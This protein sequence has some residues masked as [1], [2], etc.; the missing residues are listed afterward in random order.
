MATAE[1]STRGTA[2]A[3]L[4]AAPLLAELTAGWREGRRPLA[5]EVLDRHPALADH[6][7]VAVRL[8][9][10]EVWLREQAGLPVEAAAILERFPRW[11]QELEV[12]LQC[13]VLLGTEGAAPGYPEAGE[14]LH[15]FAL[16]AELG[17]GARGR[18]YLARDPELA[19]RPVVLKV[20][21]LRGGEHRNL[22][23]L[24]HAH[25]VPLLSAADLPDRGLRILC[26]PYHGGAPLDRLLDD[27]ARVPPAERTGRDLIGALDRASAGAPVASPAEGPAR[28]LLAGESYVR[29]VCWV[30]SCLAD[31]LEHAHR[32][33]L[34]HLDVKPSNVL[35]AAEGTPMLLD[36]HL[37][38]G[39]LRAGDRVLN[40]LGGTPGYM[41]PEQQAAMAEVKQG[42]PIS[43]PVDAR[44]DVHALGVLIYQMLAGTSRA[45]E[46]RRLRAANRRVGPGLADVVARCLAEDPARR[47]A[48]AGEFADDLRRFLDDR[49]LRGVPNRSLRERW[50]RW[51]RRHPQ[52]LSRAGASAVAMLGVASAALA[53]GHT[54]SR[55][56]NDAQA[57]LEQG[58][59]YLAEGSERQAVRVLGDAL[60]RLDSAGFLRV[61]VPSAERLHA[62]LAAERERAERLVR[63]EELHELADRLRWVLPADRGRP[64]EVRG[65]ESRLA[66]VWASRQSILGR[67][68]AGSTPPTRERVLADLRDLGLLLADLRAG[69]A[70]DGALR[71]AM[72]ILA[73]VEAACGPSAALDLERAG[74]AGRLGLV[75]EAQAALA[76]AA[77]ARPRTAWE[78]AALG[79]AQ[80]RAGDPRAAAAA[81]DRAV[82]LEPH[83]LWPHFYRGQCALRRGRYAEALSDFSACIALRPEA[84]ACYHNRGLAF[85]GLGE[86]ARA[87][88]DFAQARRLAPRPGRPVTS[89]RATSTLAGS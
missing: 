75:A 14:T 63:L 13:H 44:A 59:A 58:Q 57:A 54:A 78:Y 7:E 69:S 21:S 67:L 4:L 49:P 20:T 39:P 81:L 29:A 66:Q 53:V 84:A 8:V 76:R 70:R 56:L 73:E 40:G 50:G 45:V 30:V 64:A 15:G 82:E 25:I 47:Y 74:V 43:R 68:A 86:R 12:L 2:E 9:Y 89:S 72:A 48:D 17:R 10:E 85:A 23:R 34:V 41:A 79:R 88:R 55:R 37:A 35:L 61:V 51:R 18:V 24:Q 3:S 52:G 6:A 26:L 22:A 38:G 80:L 27:L 5:E 46:P 60:K 36:F 71:E 62:Q 32:R 31:A 16:V 33:G 28:R 42:R 83:G 87:E 77:V 19:D 65:L 1:Q 11:R